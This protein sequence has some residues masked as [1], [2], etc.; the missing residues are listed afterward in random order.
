MISKTLQVHRRRQLTLQIGSRRIDGC[1]VACWPWAM[2][3]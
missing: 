2:A 1:S 3:C